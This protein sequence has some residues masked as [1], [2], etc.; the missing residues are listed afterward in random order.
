MGYY[1]KQS[2]YWKKKEV[3]KKIKPSFQEIIRMYDF[4]KLQSPAFSDCFDFLVSVEYAW[5]TQLNKSY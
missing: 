1:T 3:N 4:L 2:N 5:K